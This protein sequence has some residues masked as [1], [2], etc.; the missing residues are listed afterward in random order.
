MTLSSLGEEDVTSNVD[1][2]LMLLLLI[3]RATPFQLRESVEEV[4]WS[5]DYLSKSFHHHHTD[6][7]EVYL[8]RCPAVH[9]L[10]R[11][12]APPHA[13]DK[14]RRSGDLPV[15]MLLPLLLLNL[16]RKAGSKN[17]LEIYEAI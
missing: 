8:P 10:V 4:F 16:Q 1:P 13:L 3:P 17:A 11:G 7:P 6:R 9:R 2:L 14:P 5:K 12:M 15:K